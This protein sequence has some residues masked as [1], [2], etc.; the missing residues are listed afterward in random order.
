[1]FGKS[2]RETLSRTLEPLCTR[3]DHVLAYDADGISWREGP[4]RYSPLQTVSSYHCGFFGCSV[5][6][7]PGEGYFTVIDTPDRPHF[8]EE[9]GANVFQCPH[10]GTWMYRSR[11]EEGSRWECGVDECSYWRDEKIAVGMAG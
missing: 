1:M 5:R 9:P 11:G 3:H 7:T 2:S 6:Y 4:D 10:H 8:I